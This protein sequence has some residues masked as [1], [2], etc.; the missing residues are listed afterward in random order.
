MGPNSI[1]QFFVDTHRRFIGGAAMDGMLH[2]LLL[3]GVERV[4][5]NRGQTTELTVRCYYVPQ[6]TMI[7]QSCGQMATHAAPPMQTGPK[8][9]VYLL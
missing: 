1:V 8:F 9:P 6:W 3:F 2:L 4:L 7:V 5:L